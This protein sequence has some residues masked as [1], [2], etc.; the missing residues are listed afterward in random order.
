MALLN[1]TN[2]GIY[3]EQADIYI[4]PSKKVQKA[5][6]THAHSDHARSGHKS[7]LCTHTTLPVLKLRLGKNIPASGIGY[8][9]PITINGVKFSFHP[10][11]H[12]IGS[13]QIR[14]EYKGEVWVVSGDY[15]VEDDGVSEVYEPVKCHHFITECTFGLPIYKWGKQEKTFDQINQWWAANAAEKTTSLITAYSL[16]KAQRVIQN[17]DK[18]IGRIFTH[19]AVENINKAFRHLGIPIVK[20]TP[21]STKIT[22]KELENALIVTP[23]SGGISNVITKI[24][25]LSIASASGWMMS[26][27]RRR[28]VNADRAFVLSDHVDWI[29]L[30]QTIKAT[31][32]IHIYPTH[33]YTDALSKYLKENGY[34]TEIK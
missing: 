12:I 3:C 7:Y 21:L 5:L 29:G 1:F 30:I 13:A 33:G 16:G 17:V 32:A 25:A 23:S 26:R 6:I 11:G 27:E 22:T 19:P 28:K 18:H 24:R 2:K 14:V 8:G 4:D 9:E 34:D 15:K 10:A 20:T 31:E